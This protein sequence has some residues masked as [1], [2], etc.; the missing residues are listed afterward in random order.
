MGSDVVPDWGQACNSTVYRIV[1][2]SVKLFFRFPANSANF[3][4]EKIFNFFTILPWKTLCIQDIVAI[5][6]ACHNAKQR[7]F[8]MY[9]K[10][11]YIIWTHS[12]FCGI[13]T[14]YQ[15]HC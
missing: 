1:W 13:L 2:R 14:P 5:F 11:H 3:F 9:F 8:L 4:C 7:S 12:G 15:Q 6:A 10:L